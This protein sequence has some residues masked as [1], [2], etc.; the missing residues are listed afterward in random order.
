MINENLKAVGTLVITITGPDGKIKEQ[1]VT[2]NLVVDSG[3]ASVASSLFSANT[4][5]YFTYMTLGTG[6]TAALYSDTL[7]QT[8]VAAARITGSNT[9]SAAVGGSG[10]T[11][12]TWVGNWQSTT[13]NQITY[14]S[15]STTPAVGQVVTVGASNTI[16]VPSGTVIISYSGGVA[17]LNNA[18][19]GTTNAT[20]NWINHATSGVYS[21]T[22]GPNVPVSSGNT[23]V[24]EAG[25]F[26]NATI[27]TG[28]M[29]SRVVFSAVNKTGGLDTLNI[30]WI[31]SIT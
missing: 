6:T 31:I 8:E 4:A 28:T 27:N 1:T 29:L 7:I 2:P 18:L 22:W 15:G 10:A 5:P 14:V 26:N 24:T 30:S 9:I 21:W 23:A 12:G 20:A 13:P 3:K 19:T 25:I 16:T 11:L 17:T